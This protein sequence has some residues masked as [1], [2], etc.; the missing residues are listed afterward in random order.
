MGFVTDYRE[1]VEREN[2]VLASAFRRAFDAAE[3]EAI[4]RAMAARRGLDWDELF[5]LK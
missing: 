2:D 5:A 4:G 3:L 1:H